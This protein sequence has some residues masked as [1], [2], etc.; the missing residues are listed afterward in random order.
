MS[1]NNSRLTSMAINHNARESRNST[2]T[3][4]GLMDEFARNLLTDEPR[5]SELIGDRDHTWLCDA[6]AAYLATGDVQF[7]ARQIERHALPILAEA[8]SDEYEK[9]HAD[10][11][12]AA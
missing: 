10:I 2:P 11:Q 4:D 5:V 8:V 7:L 3:D 1:A 6:A 12:N 9:F